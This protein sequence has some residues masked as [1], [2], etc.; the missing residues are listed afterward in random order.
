MSRIRSTMHIAEYGSGS[1]LTC[2]SF[3]MSCFCFMPGCALCDAA[4]AAPVDHGPAVHI[5]MVAAS[6]PC[7]CY[8]PDCVQCVSIV[9]AEAEAEVDCSDTEQAAP[10]HLTGIAAARG[11]TS[12]GKRKR[13]RCPKPGH[14]KC[15]LAQELEEDRKGSQAESFDARIAVRASVCILMLQ[16]A[17]SV[18]ECIGRPRGERWDCG[19]CT[20]VVGISQLQL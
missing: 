1:G 19:K 20:A 18:L 12:A 10:L 3:R 17:L 4:K 6:R 8:M 11:S 14:V 2:W 15:T 13:K 16:P 5:G 7:S 9:A